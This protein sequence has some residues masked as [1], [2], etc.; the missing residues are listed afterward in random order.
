MG[1][2]QGKVSLIRCQW[3]TPLSWQPCRTECSR[4]P[5][6]HVQ[7]PRGR[8]VLHGF[9]AQKEL[10]WRSEKKGQSPRQGHFKGIGI[11][12]ECDRDH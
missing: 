7:R 12:W 2:S 1:G 10:S 8:S 6:E 3:N 9:E 4:Q 11:Y 5:T